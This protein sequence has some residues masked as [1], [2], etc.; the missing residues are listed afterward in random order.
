MRKRD[1]KI[2]SEYLHEGWHVRILALERDKDYPGPFNGRQQDF[3]APSWVARCPERRPCPGSY[4]LQPTCFFRFLKDP[5]QI[6]TREEGRIL[7][8]DPAALH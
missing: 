3:Q 6:T 1:V 7:T 4:R 2:G 5:F 8:P